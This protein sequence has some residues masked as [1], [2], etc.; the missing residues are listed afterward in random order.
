M[1]PKD[2]YKKPSIESILNL[3]KPDMQQVDDLIIAHMQSDIPLIPQLAG[4]LIHA[5]GKRIRPM[6]SCISARM[7]GINTHRQI[8]Q[9]AIYATCVEFIHTATLLHDDVIDNSDMRRGHPS[10]HTVWGNQATVLVGDFLFSRAF[11]LMANS[12]VPSATQVLSN[13]SCRLAEG[14]I[15]QLQTTQNLHTSIAKYLAMIEAKTAVL[16]AAAAKVGG[17]IARQNTAVCNA[18][19]A[20]GENLGVAFQMVDDALD[21]HADADTMGKNIGDDFREGKTTLPVLTVWENATD[22]EKEFLNRTFAQ[23]QQQQ[24]D[25]KTMLELIEKYNAL[26]TTFDMAKKYGDKAKQ[27]L[28]QIPVQNAYKDALITMVDYAIYRVY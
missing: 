8:Q 13:A 9:T 21:Y 25:F 19:Y 28:Q 16:F 11:D 18:L 22:T 14:E 2:M 26:Q 20:Y 23:G 1:I 17:V 4:Y 3:S 5:G 24:S 12:D 15:L 7:C 6:L 10:A 27:S